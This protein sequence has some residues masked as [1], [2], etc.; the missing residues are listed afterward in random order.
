MLQMAEDLK[1][2]MSA[3]TLRRRAKMGLPMAEAA[4]AAPEQRQRQ[5][6]Q[7]ITTAG[8]AVAGTVTIRDRTLGAVGGA[9]GGEV[10]A[11][12]GVCEGEG[13]GEDEVIIGGEFCL[14]YL[15][16]AIVLGSSA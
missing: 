11:A 15:M 7:P 9:V 12:A 13:E 4:M 8:V 1:D 14:V 5:M 2:P 16:A 10:G 3:S 6:T